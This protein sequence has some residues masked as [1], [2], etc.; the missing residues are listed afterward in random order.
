[1]TPDDERTSQRSAHMSRIGQ[2]NTKPE[3]QVRR[4]LFAAGFRYRLHD[5]SLPG[6]P[7]LVFPRWRTAMFVHGCFWHGHD[8]RLFQLPKSNVEFWSEKIARNRE[9][10]QLVA[11]RLVEAGWHV[12]VVW[13]CEIRGPK[14]DAKMREQKIVRNFADFVSQIS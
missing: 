13:E 4:A 2:K 10:D 11:K 3:L 6:S 12:F 14:R 5:R 7:D 8:C 1:M 9:R